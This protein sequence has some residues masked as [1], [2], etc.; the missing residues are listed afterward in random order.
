VIGFSRTGVAVARHLLAAGTAVRVSDRRPAADFADALAAL[1]PWLPPS[2]ATAAS[3][4][5]G[6]RPAGTPAGAARAASARLELH[7]GG[8]DAGS[9]AGVAL[10]IPSPGVPADAP[11]LRAAQQ[12][13]IPI[14]SEIELA[15]RALTIPILAVTGTNGKSTTTTLLGDML[16]AGGA[17]PFVGGN[18]GTPLIVAAGGE[19]DVAVAEISS[20]QLEWVER[21]RPRVGVLLNVTDDHLD[22]YADLDSYGATKLRVFARQ[23]ANDVAVLNGG[24]PWIRRHAGAIPAEKLW[25]GAGEGV[26]L[27]ADAAAIRLRRAGR[28][29]EVYPLHAVRLAGAHNRENMMAAI[30]AARAFGVPPAAVQTALERF[31]GLEH[32]VELVRERDGVRW[33]NDSKGTNAGAVI[34]SLESFA[35]GVILLA[36]GVP[37]GGDYG[38]LIAPV[39]RAV[40]RALLFGAARELLART[41]AGATEVEIVDSLEEAVARAAAVAVRGDTVLLSPA[42]ASFDMFRDYAERGRRFKALVEAL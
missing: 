12:R 13:G 31:A 30:A 29:E 14:V 10:V 3:G 2:V 21:F 42:C 25:F 23:D 11:L 4:P 40:K 26:A 28:E 39:R 22:R 9:L 18:L 34:K 15:A 35:G 6:R 36:G 20:F 41:L 27:R 8:E 19:Y 32:R 7:L 1:A 33:V 37:K 24:D 16:R 38:V 17:R 5:V